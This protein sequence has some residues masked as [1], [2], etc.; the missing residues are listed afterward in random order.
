MASILAL[1]GCR[2][3]T[4]SP[5]HAA[6]VRRLGERALAL[7]RALSEDVMSACFVVAGTAPLG[8]TPFD[9]E[10]AEDVFHG[11][12]PPGPARVICATAFGVVCERRVERDAE[13]A[14]GAVLERM[15]LLKPK[16]LLESIEELL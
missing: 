2:A 14:E 4:L 10:S 9:A 16:V 5:R 6:G 11:M 1:A 7:R 3:P 8:D 13:C 15:V 12:S